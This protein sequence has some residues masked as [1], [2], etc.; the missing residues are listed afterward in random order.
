MKHILFFLFAMKQRK[1][2]KERRGI[3]GYTEY[4]VVIKKKMMIIQMSDKKL[5]GMMMI[6]LN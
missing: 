5:I 3:R 1:I 2:T 6:Y 4:Q